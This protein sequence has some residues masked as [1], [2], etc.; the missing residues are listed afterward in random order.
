VSEIK[1]FREFRR[2]KIEY[3]N[4]TWQQAWGRRGITKSLS[5][6]LI[7]LHKRI[8]FA[9]TKNSQNSKRIEFA[10]I[11]VSCTIVDIFETASS[12]HST[13]LL[14]GK[15]ELFLCDAIRNL[16]EDRV[17]VVENLLNNGGGFRVDVMHHNAPVFIRPTRTFFS[18]F[19]IYTLELV[20]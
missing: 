6:Y 16:H 2:V 18:L 9:S 7:E 13:C 19:I 17:W 15:R 5:K 14:Y 4:E 8:K 12:M 11:K 20:L 1:Q 3:L 10:V